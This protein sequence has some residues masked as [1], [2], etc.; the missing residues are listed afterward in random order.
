MNCLLCKGKI[1]SV[2]KENFACDQNVTNWFDP[3]M[4]VISKEAPKVLLRIV[5]SNYPPIFSSPSD[6]TYLLL[7]NPHNF[8][9]FDCCAIERYA[10]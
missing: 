6:I 7:S 2:L 9:G 4:F 8:A 3:R 1:E 5:N 10:R